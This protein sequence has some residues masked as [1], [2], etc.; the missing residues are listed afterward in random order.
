MKTASVLHITTPVTECPVP[1]GLGMHIS[2]HFLLFPHLPPRKRN[3]KYIKS[4][5]MAMMYKQCVCFVLCRHW[6][7]SDKV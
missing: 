7:K 5:I 3:F 4:M 1:P 2:F 6:K